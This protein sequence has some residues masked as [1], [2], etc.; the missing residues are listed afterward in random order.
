MLVN[1]LLDENRPNNIGI[2]ILVRQYWTF[3]MID[4]PEITYTVLK[5]LKSAVVQEEHNLR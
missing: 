5:F 3:P 1:Q 4:Y 2:C